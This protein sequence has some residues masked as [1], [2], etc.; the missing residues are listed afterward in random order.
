[1]TT[2]WTARVEWEQLA[3]GTDDDLLDLVD[4]LAPFS[5]AI[6]TEKP[7]AGVGYPEIWSAIL[8]L[9]AATLREATAAAIES[10]E[11]A[12]GCAATGVEVLAT[13]EFDRRVWT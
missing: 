8:A 5:G 1:M 4:R 10:I 7:S 2:S 12:T 3:P 9:E 13:D 11:Q 6:G